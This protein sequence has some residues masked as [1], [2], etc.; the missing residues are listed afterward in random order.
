MTKRLSRRVSRPALKLAGL[1]AALI[2]A[3]ALPAAA[4]DAAHPTVVE[5]FQSQG[6]S[7]CPPALAN[8]NA[9]S[10]RRDILPLAFAVD[11]WDRLGWKDTFDK[12]EFTQRQYS[13]SRAMGLAGVYTP[14]VIV[15]GR[16]EGVGAEPEDMTSLIARGDRGDGGPAI[17]F[18]GEGVAI[19]AAKVGA[20]GADVWL[21]R[22]DPRNL[23]VKVLRGENAGRTLAHRNIV[24]EITLIG[25]W[26]GEAAAFAISP[27]GDPRWREAV[28]VQSS[29]E[30]P[31]IAAAAR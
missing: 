16:V 15:N 14:Q 30:G 7:S 4:A 29:G 2:G 18:R 26:N 5:L 31:V 3:G 24:R 25:H 21:V 23:E 11:Y 22:Y 27:G 1:A 10:D 19:G 17:A 9:L 13:Y 20:A 28:L 12:P 6:C 8:L